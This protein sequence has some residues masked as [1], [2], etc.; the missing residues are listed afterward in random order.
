MTAAPVTNTN[1][2]A[3]IAV[4]GQQQITVRLR[5]GVSDKT[6]GAVRAEIG[7]EVRNGIAE[8]STEE[9]QL[10]LVAAE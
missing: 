1:H 7:A 4:P 2:V 6:I 3:E 5:P 10:T 9:K 8:I